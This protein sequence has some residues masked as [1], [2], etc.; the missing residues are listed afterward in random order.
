MA[1][2]NEN[3]TFI[4]TRKDV[5]LIEGLSF[6]TALKVNSVREEYEYIESNCSWLSI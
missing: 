2:E 1:M 4:D 6:D 5:K 3:Y